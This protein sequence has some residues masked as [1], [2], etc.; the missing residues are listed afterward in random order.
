M[1]R[2]FSISVV[3]IAS[4]FAT[5]QQAPGPKPPGPAAPPSTPLTD[6]EKMDRVAEIIAQKLPELHGSAIWRQ[7]AAVQADL[8]I[9]FGGQPALQGVLTYEPNRR[10]ARIDLNGGGSIIHDGQNVQVASTNMTV[11]EARQ[12]LELWPRLLAAPL[13]LRDRHVQPTQFRSVYL[14]GVNY[15]SIKL[16]YRNPQDPDKS[17]W[18]M[19]Y[20]DPIKHVVKAIANIPLRFFVKDAGAQDRFAVLF[21]E[22]A[23]LESVKLPSKWTFWKWDN[24]LL[25]EP[26]GTAAVTTVKFVSPASDFFEIKPASP[27]PASTPQPQSAGSSKPS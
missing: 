3:L 18:R 15:D 13:E 1:N 4:C 7:K 10:R 21:D 14:K 20:S 27:A 22:Y 17:D 11:D 5:A 24:E 12:H 9:E 23:E 2:M 8:H 16:T 19:M 26:I 25:G 6:E